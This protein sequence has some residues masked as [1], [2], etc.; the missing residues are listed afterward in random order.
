[1]L[2]P[3]RVSA[4]PPRGIDPARVQWRDHRG[5][6]LRRWDVSGPDIPGIGERVYGAGNNATP[7][8]PAKRNEIEHGGSGMPSHRGPETYRTSAAA[9]LHTFS[10]VKPYSRNTTSPG[11]EAPKRSTPSTSP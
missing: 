10:T 6:G 3:S 1:M 2:L 8:L 4:R 9:R 7:S 5:D 11:A